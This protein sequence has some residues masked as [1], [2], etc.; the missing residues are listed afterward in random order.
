MFLEPCESPVLAR[1]G[2]VGWCGLGSN[3]RISWIS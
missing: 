2:R 1:V 3:Y